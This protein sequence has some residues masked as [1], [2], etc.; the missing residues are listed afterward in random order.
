MQQLVKTTRATIRVEVPL[1]A[2]GSA[3]RRVATIGLLHGGRRYASTKIL[4]IEKGRDEEEEEDTNYTKREWKA[5]RSRAGLVAA[6]TQSAPASLAR[7]EKEA[8]QSKTRSLSSRVQ[9]SS[10]PSLNPSQEGK[11]GGENCVIDCDALERDLSSH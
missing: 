8:T 5:G 1:A 6:K 11:K 4:L 10:F 3:A 2:A 7:T 9:S